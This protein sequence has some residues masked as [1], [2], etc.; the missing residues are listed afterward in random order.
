MSGVEEAVQASRGGAVIWVRVKTGCNCTRFPAGYDTWRKAVEMEVQAQ[1]REGRANREIINTVR[2]FFDLDAGQV[3]IAYGAT[4]PEKG[5]WVAR[6][7][8]EVVTRINHEL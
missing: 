2:N 7:P 3:A 8:I 4:G 5:I 1:P 6:Q